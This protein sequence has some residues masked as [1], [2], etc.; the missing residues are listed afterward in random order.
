[1][2][3]WSVVSENFFSEGVRK[4]IETI[5]SVLREIVQIGVV[6]SGWKWLGLVGRGRLVVMVGCRFIG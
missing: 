3:G 2:C 1:M 6:E 5:P 4:K